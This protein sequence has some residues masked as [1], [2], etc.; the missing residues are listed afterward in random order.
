MGI[1]SL[2]VCCTRA[3]V[4]AFSIIGAMALERPPSLFVKSAESEQMASSVTLEDALVSLADSSSVSNRAEL[5]SFAKMIWV[6]WAS[7]SCSWASFICCAS[8]S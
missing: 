6:L 5:D 1:S 2:P 7:R 3:L 8:V 4:T